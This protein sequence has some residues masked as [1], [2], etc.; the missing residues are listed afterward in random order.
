MR[1]GITT[2]LI[3][4]LS[5]VQKNW[6]Q[7]LPVLF[8]AWLQNR[9]QLLKTVLRINRNEVFCKKLRNQISG[10]L[11]PCAGTTNTYACRKMIVAFDR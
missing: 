3:V 10:S 8:E 1:K 7:H 5:L 11:Q 9:L 6:L 4:Y 2:A